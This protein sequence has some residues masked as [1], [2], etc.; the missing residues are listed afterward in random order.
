MYKLPVRSCKTPTT[1]WRTP[2]KWHSMKQRGINL[3]YSRVFGKS[4]GRCRQYPRLLQRSK[5]Q[6][7]QPGW[8]SRHS[9]PVLFHQPFGH[10]HWNLASLSVLGFNQ[11]QRKTIPHKVERWHWVGLLLSFE[12][13]QRIYICTMQTMC[14]M[15][16]TMQTNLLSLTQVGDCLKQLW[17]LPLQPET[18]MLLLLKNT[19]SP[20]LELYP[21]PTWSTL[22][23]I[24]TNRQHFSLVASYPCNAYQQM[25]LFRSLTLLSRVKTSLRLQPLHRTSP[26]WL[27]AM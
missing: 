17:H 14:T 9:P 23:R 20:H 21:L 19:T 6:G 26:R 13:L 24:V 27:E 11:L 1:D 15:M 16:C 5:L 3:S 7:P 18:V 10:K 12:L 25:A 4:S 8:A 22:S 2:R